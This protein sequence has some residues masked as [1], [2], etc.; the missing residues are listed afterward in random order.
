MRITNLGGCTQVY[1]LDTGEEITNLTFL[2]W[3]H[4]V[5][6]MPVVMMKRCADEPSVDYTFYPEYVELNSDTTYQSPKVKALRVLC[7]KFK[8]KLKG[9]Q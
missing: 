5:G 1:D 9:T 7:S 2:S 8:A 3:S 6:D 4:A